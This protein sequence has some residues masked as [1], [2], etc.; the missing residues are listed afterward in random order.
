MTF[1]PRYYSQCATVAFYVYSRV[2]IPEQRGLF[3]NV[4]VGAAIFHPAAFGWQ[5]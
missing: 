1:L 5:L 2:I 4:N 3:G